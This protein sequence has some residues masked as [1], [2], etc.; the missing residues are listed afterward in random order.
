M[1]FAV[2]LAL[3]SSASAADFRLVDR[4]PDPNGYADRL[5]IEMNGPIEQGDSLKLN[6]LLNE[7]RTKN[8]NLFRTT[9]MRLNSKGGALDPSI[10]LAN[11][12]RDS[13]IA[14]LIDNGAVCLSGCAIVF[15][16]GTWRDGDNS[17]EPMK[18]LAPKGMLGFHAP[19]AFADTNLEPEVQRLLLPDA[20]RG[21]VIAASKL[22]KLSLKDII[23][24]SLVEELLQYKANSFLYVDDV[25]RAGRWGISLLDEA[26]FEVAEPAIMIKHADLS[27]HCSNHI[28]WDLDIS[29]AN[30]EG[31]WGLPDNSLW[32]DGMDNGCKYE[33][34]NGTVSYQVNGQSGTVVGWQTLPANTKLA[35]LTPAQLGINADAPDP[36]ENPPPSQIDGP[37]HLGYQWIGGWVGAFWQDSIAHATYRKCDGS[38]SLI[39]FRCNHGTGMISRSINLSLLGANTNQMPN[40]STQVDSEYELGGD[41]VVFEDGILKAQITLSKGYFTFEQVK[42][43]KELVIRIDGASHRVHLKGSR[44]AMEAMESSCL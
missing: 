24:A 4:T 43:G 10:E 11:L 15:M 9:T 14:T 29:Y 28:F 35:G 7:L 6:A 32:F 38:E 3:I 31:D 8:E 21:G 25:D 1:A 18:T 33:A 37:C 2:M 34:N 20:E 16:A 5:T 42:S 23:P 27:T 17:Y 44:A 36:F 19:F 39:T 30:R 40:V 12:V 26:F 41:T 22:V 13:G